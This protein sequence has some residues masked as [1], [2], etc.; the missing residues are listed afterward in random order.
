ME[1]WKTGVRCHVLDDYCVAVQ[2]ALN[3][4]FDRN[5]IHQRAVR[6]YGMFEVAKEYE[7]VVKVIIQNKDFSTTKSA[8]EIGARCEEGREKK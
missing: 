7:R 5:Y 4:Y 3:G 6:K 2:S 1:Q 8:F